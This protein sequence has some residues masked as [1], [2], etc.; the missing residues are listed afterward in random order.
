VVFPGLVFDNLVELTRDQ[1]ST[2]G[3][4]C[5]GLAPALCRSHLRLIHRAALVQQLRPAYSCIMMMRR[6][7]LPQP[8]AGSV[9]VSTILDAL[10]RWQHVR[11]R[12]ATMQAAGLVGREVGCCPDIPARAVNW[13]KLDPSSAVGRLRRTEL[14]QLARSMHRMCRRSQP[15]LTQVV[16][17][18]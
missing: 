4:D 17:T 14:L 16:A 1:R 15:S 9:D 7:G 6:T 12:L 5:R 13:L 3:R 2:R 11:P 10:T 18:P 8:T